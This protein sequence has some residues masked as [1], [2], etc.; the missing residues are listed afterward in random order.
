MKAVA[1]HHA[2][3][4][5]AAALVLGLA[6]GFYFAASHHVSHG[7]L[8]PP[9]EG[10]GSVSLA[11][12]RLLMPAAA[13]IIVAAGVVHVLR[14]ARVS[15]LDAFR[16]AV[17][18]LR[19]RAAAASAAATT[20][21]SDL[22]LRLAAAQ[23]A[24]LQPMTPAQSDATFD[25]NDDAS[26]SSLQGENAEP[27]DLEPSV[28]SVPLST[29]AAM[30]GS[31]ARSASP[32]APA[33]A[34][35]ATAV[36][37]QS[38]LLGPSRGERSG[39]EVGPQGMSTSGVQP[40]QLQASGHSSE[41]QLGVHGLR[42]SHSSSCSISSSR[43][44]TNNGMSS[45]VRDGRVPAGL[46]CN[47]PTSSGD[48]TLAPVSSLGGGGGGCVSFSSTGAGIH[49]HGSEGGRGRSRIRGS[50]SVSSS[51][52][53]SNAALR[54]TQV[55][56]GRSSS[57]V[58]I[59]LLIAPPVV[60]PTTATSFP[61]GHGVTAY[62]PHHPSSRV[63]QSELAHLSEAAQAAAQQFGWHT[64]GRRTAIPALQQLAAS[65]SADSRLVAPPQ[66]QPS[67]GQ[68][69]NQADISRSELVEQPMDAL[70]PVVDCGGS[71]GASRQRRSVRRATTLP[72]AQLQAW[73]RFCSSVVQPENSVSVSMAG[74][75][76]PNSHHVAAAGTSG[77]TLQLPAQPPPSLDPQLLSVS[78]IDQSASPSHVNVLNS[79]PMPQL[80]LDQ[81]A[82][83]SSGGRGR[84][85]EG[86]NNDGDDEAAF[87]S[88]RPT[89]T[90][91]SDESES[92]AA[93]SSQQLRTLAYRLR[94][95]AAAGSSA[96]S[97]ARSSAERPRAGADPGSTS[98]GTLQS[99][100]WALSL[101]GSP[102]D[103]ADTAVTAAA[104]AAA[105]ALP[106]Q[107]ALLSAP[108]RRHAP[109]TRALKSPYSLLPPAGVAIQEEEET[110]NCSLPEAAGSPAGSPPNHPTTTV[111]AAAAAAATQPGSI[112]AAPTSE[113]S[114]SVSK[115]GSVASGSGSL[116][117]A[118][119][120]AT[121]LA[122]TVI[123]LG[124]ASLATGFVEV[125]CLLV[126][127]SESALPQPADVKGT[128]G[129]PPGPTAQQHAVLHPVPGAEKIAVAGAASEPHVS[130]LVREAV[131]RCVRRGYGT[132]RSSCCST[133]E[134]WWR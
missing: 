88:L 23:A 90:S 94:G 123:H 2:L 53:R 45:M 80:L 19:A 68:G 14:L 119:G 43:S 17:R 130:E 113:A 34:P 116:S 58:R 9:T 126:C 65:T 97:S 83:G 10:L 73:K 108:S 25:S 29:A 30:I 98:S 35:A 52:G 44:H 101:P 69:A 21:A 48:T 57:G 4:G 104:A 20:A 82:T 56:D 76:D 115:S 71:S 72:V 39:D 40:V 61:P 75:S 7:T 125:T 51:S 92:T 62:L 3:A 87:F 121:Q 24:F 55:G 16:T 26:R 99:A 102:D 28:Q 38:G 66:Q 134:S 84:G 8:A 59:K 36:D 49:L 1:A 11:D 74:S 27:V 86:R 13:C 15:V 127:P 122:S 124:P 81:A 54:V 131:G 37:Q 47:V 106:R 64:R 46:H 129:T 41:P 133:V 110:S 22:R 31:L 79:Q 109:A 63:Q 95:W 85:G 96:H 32:H 112:E 5:A 6:L 42:P 50:T 93:S 89:T 100:L 128:A 107:P 105:A 70:L 111:T 132:Y 67:A 91:A 117:D 118:A 78:G 114:S 18:R 60:S 33:P 12:A 120:A 77:R 103:D